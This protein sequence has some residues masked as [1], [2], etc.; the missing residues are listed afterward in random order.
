MQYIF[1]MTMIASVAQAT[2]TTLEQQITDYASY[3]GAIRALIDSNNNPQLDSWV[4]K[5]TSLTFKNQ[6]AITRL[7][8]GVDPTTASIQALSVLKQFNL[9]AMIYL[10][11]LL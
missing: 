11:L 4:K 8:F 5:Q 6:Q 9:Y 10:P 7:A 3:G 1:V 2:L